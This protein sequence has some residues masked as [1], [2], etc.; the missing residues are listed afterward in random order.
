MLCIVYITLVV[1]SEGL[2]KTLSLGIKS[3]LELEILSSTICL[4]QTRQK[5]AELPLSMIPIDEF[6]DSGNQWRCVLEVEWIEHYVKQHIK[7]TFEQRVLVFQF[8]Y[9]IE[10][11]VFEDLEKLAMSLLGLPISNAVI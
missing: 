10:K 8:H 6:S 7:Q 5:S 9:P 4:S 11:P 1:H 3:V 2:L